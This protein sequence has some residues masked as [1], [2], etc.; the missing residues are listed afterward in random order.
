M[1]SPYIYLPLLK[2]SHKNFSFICKKL[3]VFIILYAFSF[4][5][6]LKIRLLKIPALNKIQK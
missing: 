5:N 4:Y 3:T 2:K 6:K 1:G